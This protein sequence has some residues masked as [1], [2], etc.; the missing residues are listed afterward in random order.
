MDNKSLEEEE[1]LYNSQVQASNEKLKTTHEKKEYTLSVVEKRRLAQQD[2]IEK[3]ASQA[4]QD[5]INLTV[6]PRVGITP[7]KEVFTLYDIALGKLTIFIPKS[8]PDAKEDPMVG[9][10]VEEPK[11][12]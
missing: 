7:N 10:V 3:F 5:I 2:L 8:K 9:E 12:P 1:K 11:K 4:L 6:L